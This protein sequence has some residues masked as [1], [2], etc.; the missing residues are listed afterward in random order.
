MDEKI[1]NIQRLS[2]PAAYWASVAGFIALMLL[3]IGAV[4]YATVTVEYQWRWY[5][6]P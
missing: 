3:V 5:K 2:N 4:Y 6:A 1:S